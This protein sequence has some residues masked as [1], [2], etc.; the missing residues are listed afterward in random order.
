MD[1][2]QGSCD[3][4]I[5]QWLGFAEQTADECV[6]L[7]STLSGDIAYQLF[8]M[9]TDKGLLVFFTRVHAQGD[10]YLDPD[11]IYDAQNALHDMYPDLEA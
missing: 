7:E 10:L 1:A 11:T 4:L 8:V 5:V 9:P 3:N 2:V 6:I